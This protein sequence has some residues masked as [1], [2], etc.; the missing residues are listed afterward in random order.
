MEKTTLFHVL[1]RVLS[2]A[3]IREKAVRIFSKYDC[4]S[5]LKRMTMNGLVKKLKFIL[6]MCGF[7]TILYMFNGGIFA[8]KKEIIRIV[9]NLIKRRGLDNTPYS[10]HLMLQYRAILGK[11]ELFQMYNLQTLELISKST[12]EHEEMMNDMRGTH[13]S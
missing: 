3:L 4:Y 6:G 1:M 2:I 7:R 10:L 5:N 11:S 13:F 9:G 12:I 8:D